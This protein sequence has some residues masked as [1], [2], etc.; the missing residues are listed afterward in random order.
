MFE[1][2]RIKLTLWYVLISMIIS[3][4]FS[5]T[6]FT[7]LNRQLVENERR[8]EMRMRIMQDDNPFFIPDYQA[9]RQDE[10]RVENSLKLNLLY[11]NLLI[12]IA[13]STAGYF[14]A[15]KVLEPIKES[16]EKQNQFVADASHELR[17]PLTALQTAIEVNLRDKKLTLPQAKTV[18]Q[19]NLH[20]VN[21]LRSL[22]DNLLVLARIQN[23]Q[24]QKMAAVSLKEIVQQAINNVTY[25]AK[26]KNISF[27]TSLLD[28][29][30]VGEKDRLIQMFVIFFDNAIKY[31]PPKRTILVDTKK[32]NSQA[33]IMIKDEGLGIEQEDLPHIFE[34]FYRA[35]KSRSGAEGY[36]LGLAIAKE[37]IDVHKGTVDITSKIKKG[38]TVFIKLPLK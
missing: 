6:I 11:I 27:D 13:S 29:T 8:V 3:V 16:V 32:T 33:I 9:I 4:I 37:I 17:T 22:S 19:E 2:A 24:I 23:Q 12:L 26:G 28:I 21:N 1:S 25:L 10:E 31:S 18:L 5:V 36:G 20:D 7:I 14:M 30:I 38:T 35:D 34:R 15:G